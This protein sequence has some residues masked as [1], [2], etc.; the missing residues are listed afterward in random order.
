MSMDV[1]QAKKPSCSILA[2]ILLFIL[3][4][5]LLG[6]GIT[7]AYLLISGKGNNYELGTL[8]AFLFL[9]AGIEVVV[10]ARYF[11]VFREVREDREEEL[12][13]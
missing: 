8:L 9:V 2:M 6:L 13:W 7:F 4:A 11:M 3:A 5:V 12:L 10:Y 1:I